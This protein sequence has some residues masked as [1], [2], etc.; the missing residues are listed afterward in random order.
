M[1]SPEGQEIWS[2]G[3]YRELVPLEKIVTTD[4]FADPQGEVV[5]AS[6]YN[7]PG[8]WPLELLIT[9]TFED[10][11]AGTRMTL[12]HDGIPA[13]T[14]R[15]QTSAGW[16][17]SFDKLAELVSATK[18]A[19]RLTALPGRQEILITSVF[20]A[21]RELVF[22]AYTE[23]A[24]IERW[25]GPRRY[26]TVVDRLE[27]RTGGAWRFLNRDA[28]GGEF[29]FH[30]VYHD[31]SPDRIVGTFEF[32][33]VPGHVSLETAVFEERGGTTTV[34]GRS[35]FQT[36]EDRDAMLQAGMEEGAVE[37]MDRLAALLKELVSVKKAA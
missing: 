28:E 16:N 8:E 29:A 3:T 26:T 21:P 1:R 18:H 24:L 13:G 10:A 32:E 37:T 34:T 23:P 19:A 25:W 11:G 12:R 2:T 6:Y 7:M 22:R 17:E 33:G 30:G 14:M 36:V 15:E 20:D 31:V 9:V 4:S 5:P 27:A 35:V